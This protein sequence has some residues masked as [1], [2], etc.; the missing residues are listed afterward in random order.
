MCS[1]HTEHPLG[2]N[3]SDDVTTSPNFQVWIH[4]TKSTF[5]CFF[6]SLSVKHSFSSASMQTFHLVR[7]QY[8]ENVKPNMVKRPITP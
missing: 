7:V 8:A 1:V 3:V 2:E 6:P 5:V 4:G